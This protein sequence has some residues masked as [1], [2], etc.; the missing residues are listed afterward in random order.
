MSS[1]PASIEELRAAAKQDL[2]AS[3]E[4][5]AR[6][7]QLRSGGPEATT[8]TGLTLMQQQHKE[9]GWNLI[10]DIDLIED[11]GNLTATDRTMLQA[12]NAHLAVHDLQTARLAEHRDL[13]LGSKEWLEAADESD[14]GVPVAHS[15]EPVEEIQKSSVED[16]EEDDPPPSKST[17]PRLYQILDVDPKT[18]QHLF[19]DTLDR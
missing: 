12:L 11:N 5:Q 17:W 14:R 15:S 2:A 9:I 8:S 16:A 1:T 3:N 7:D 10:R 18:P 6:I 13:L 19:H 4:L